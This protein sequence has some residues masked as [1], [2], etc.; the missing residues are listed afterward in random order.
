LD[1]DQIYA[2]MQ[3]FIRQFIHWQVCSFLLA[4]AF[5]P[6]TFFFWRYVVDFGDA[7]YLPH[8]LVIHALWGLCWVLISL[9][10]AQTWYEWTLKQAISSYDI[11]EANETNEK[12]IIG[13]FP[14]F[15]IGMFNVVASIIVALATFSSPIIKAISFG[16]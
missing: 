14:E 16:N 1:A 15:P 2:L 8:A 12:A 3:A 13:K 9:P 10:L 11:R 5:I 7:R 4:G 6:Y